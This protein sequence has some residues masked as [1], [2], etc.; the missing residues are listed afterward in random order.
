MSRMSE[1]LRQ[2]QAN[3]GPPSGGIEPVL[4]ENVEVPVLGQ[5]TEETVAEE[6]PAEDVAVEEVTAEEEVAEETAPEEIVTEEVVESV[7]EEAIVDER[8][9]E[10]CA[11]DEGVAERG[12]KPADGGDASREVVSLLSPLV[13]RDKEQYDRLADNILAQQSAGQSAVL[14]FTS[15]G[16]GEGKSSTLASLS[17][18]L[19]ERLGEEIVAVDANFRNPTLASHFGIWAER[20]LV[21]VV[22]GGANW[23]EVVRPTSVKRLSVLPG[24][25]FSTDDG[26]PPSDVALSPVLDALRLHY[27]VVL[28]DGASLAYPEVAP[29][30]RLCEATY[31]VAE[32]G[33]TPRGAARRAVRLLERCGG[34][35]LGCVLT[36]C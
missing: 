19:A 21:D 8:V 23:R 18:V 5:P 36:G 32:L 24:G 27:R 28:V 29:L 6:V 20:S 26:S 13:E 25:R 9:A 14:L 30:G 11:G 22:A 34:Q 3:M 35:V 1:A 2:I 33:H 16:D 17:V 7:R 4:P 10:A 12:S 15:V 31:L